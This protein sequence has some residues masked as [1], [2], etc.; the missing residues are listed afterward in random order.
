M[1]CQC[2][3]LLGRGLVDNLVGLLGLGL[4]VVGGVVVGLVLLIE[5]GVLL[6]VGCGKS[7]LAQF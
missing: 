3:E 6:G 4:G 7:A 5:V 2:L 1:A